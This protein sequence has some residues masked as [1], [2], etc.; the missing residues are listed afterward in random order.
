MKTLKDQVSS[1]RGFHANT[2]TASGYSRSS[3]Q[4]V[5]PPLTRIEFC[6]DGEMQKNFLLQE[7]EIQEIHQ[8]QQFRLL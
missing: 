1:L 5:H 3:L 7:E 4:L 6:G 2:Q 8:P